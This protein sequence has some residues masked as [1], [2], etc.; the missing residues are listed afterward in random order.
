[1]EEAEKKYQEFIA[2]FYN[3]N[4][5]EA[6]SILSENPEINNY[7]SEEK[8]KIMISYLV[9]TVN[10]DLKKLNLTLNNLEK[11]MQRGIKE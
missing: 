4:Y 7:I 2:H 10:F 6:L 8:A 3:E 9:E 5:Q 11:L 1:M